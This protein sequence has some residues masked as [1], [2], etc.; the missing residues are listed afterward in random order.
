[1]RVF[2]LILHFTV[3]FL[4]T[5]PILAQIDI[6]AISKSIVRVR[7]YDN[8]KIKA[9]GSGFVINAE[10]YVLTNAHLLSDAE[11]LTV[12]SLQTGAEIVAQQ[13]FAKRDMNL[14]LLHA[15]GL[16]LPPVNLSEQGDEVDRIAL[17]LKFGTADSVH[18]SQGKIAT[19]HD[20]TG[21]R[22]GDPVIH[23]L[24]HNAIV[25]SRAFGMPVFNECGDVVAIN[26]PDPGRG[27]WPFRRNAEPTDIVFALRSGDI[28]TA[29]KDREIAHTVVEEACLTAL[30]RATADSI[31]AAADSIQTAR[32]RADSLNRVRTDSIKAA[33]DS[34]KAR[35]DSIQAENEQKDLAKRAADARADSLKAATDSLQAKARDDSLRQVEQEAGY[36]SL[37]QVEKKRASQ[38]MHWIIIG[39]GT[40]VLL[41]LVGWF[42]FARRKKAQ[43]QNTATQLSE[44][45]QQATAA[46]QA[47]AQAPQRAPFRCLLEGQDNTG[48]SFVL[49][50]PAVALS[51]SVA[52]GRSPANAEFI[53]DHEAVSREHVRLLYAD[54]NLYT[55]DMGSTNGTLINGNPLNPHEPMALQDNDQ[56]E[57]GP[58]VFNVR[59]VWE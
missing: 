36:D 2:G 55:E 35:T 50:I 7:A 42:I 11:R 5:T 23:L 57:L 13:V 3:Y 27:R 58:I 17:T 14:A 39:G 6:N 53:I 49:N 22:A 54:G 12:I 4:F 16:G 19:Y 9:K 56:L 51:S 28:I 15:Q 37:R 21:T 47:A 10:G 38:Q 43:L 26:Q 46:R 44:A 30:E 52:L 33:A 34:L 25:T 24:K 18:I 31:Q 32:A 1:M 59:L 40:L 29:L 20:V 45:E 41:L 8:N 48:K